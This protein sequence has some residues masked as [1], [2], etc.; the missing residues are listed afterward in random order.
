MTRANN[1]AQRKYEKPVAWLF[2]EQLIG[3]LK[4]ALLYTAYGKKLDPRDWMTGQAFS[5]DDKP[6]TEF[7]FDYLSDAGDGTKAMYGI[8]YLALSKLW[9]KLEP[10]TT[11]LP[12]NESDRKVSTLNDGKESFTFSLPRGEFLFFGGDTAYHAA[13][14]LSLVNRVQHPF[15]YA[16][17]DLLSRKLIAE[18]EPRRPV[19]G[20]PGNHDYYDQLD[21]F[22][23]Q[24]RKPVRPEGPLPPKAG[25]GTFAQLTM[26]GFKRVQEASYAALR[27]P[28]D[29]WFWGLGTES[30][31]DRPG[32][33]L[34]RR[35]Q[36]FFLSLLD[37]GSK[38]PDKLIL[39]TCTP[40]TVVGRI[41]QEDD[42]KVA[43]PQKAL[44][45]ERPFLPDQSAG[46][47][48]LSTT[49]DAKL[50]PDQCRLD[51]SGDVHHYARYW[52]PA[53]SSGVNP[54]K[55]NSAPQPSARSYASV[56]SGAGGAFHHPSTTYDNEI[57]EQVLYPSETKSR[58]IV[59]DRIF[60]FWNVLTGGR[61]WLA[62]LI[63][64][65]TIYFGATVPQSS[66]QFLGSSKLLTSLN[67]VNKETIEP[68]IRGNN[69]C[70]SVK[71]FWLWTRVGLVTEQWQPPCTS[72]Q[73][74]YFFAMDNTWPRDLVMG[75]LFIW[76][77]LIVILVT[78]I[79][80]VSTQKIFNDQSPFETGNDPDK[81]I[82]PILIVTT[83]LVF[84]GLFS[85]KLIVITSCHS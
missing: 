81:K 58:E 82:W 80:S 39:A 10:N 71:P 6:R 17:L 54:R 45:I 60:K 9:T 43:K 52:G 85:I 37:G 41:A 30:V 62:G 79:L 18:D 28:F 47:P 12:A 24:F 32:Q 57:C 65:F 74:A 11:D 8:A 44:K 78:L 42:Q 31:S 23:R 76:V 15:N 26:A 70:E 50:E 68:T 34:D 53:T 46:K 69:P 48:D 25:G 1:A 16:Y 84:I 72:D 67:L 13:E 49:G 77:S 64:A 14:Y 56:V 75:Q 35:Q 21:G 7:W 36:D 51:L 29:W 19:F 40:S 73:P 22:R 4:G 3:R 83:L 59:A 33:N 66:R 5:F 61:V 63:I 20:I 27:L 2:G 38:T 55:H